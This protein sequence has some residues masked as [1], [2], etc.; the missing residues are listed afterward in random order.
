M[1]MENIK[2]Y[3]IPDIRLDMK[4]RPEQQ[5]LLDFTKESIL[6]NKKFVL[7]DA[8]TGCLTKNEKIN[9]YIIKDKHI[10]DEKEKS[11]KTEI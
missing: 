3:E 8:P 11:K 2:T 10:N 9:I 7:L 1:N 5:K 4:P 6:S